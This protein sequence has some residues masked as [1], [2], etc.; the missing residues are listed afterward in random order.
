MAN[1]KGG[2]LVFL[3]NPTVYTYYIKS[4]SNIVEEPNIITR[5]AL[6]STIKL[7]LIV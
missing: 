1:E 3:D 2:N 6:E 7:L 4:L 5:T